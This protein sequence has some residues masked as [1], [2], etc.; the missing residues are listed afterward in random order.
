P[1]SCVIVHRDLFD[2]LVRTGVQTESPLT[3]WLEANY[4]SVLSLEGYEFW[5]R[6][7]RH[8]ALLG[9]A[10]LFEASNVTPR[11]RISVTLAESALRGVPDTELG[12]FFSDMS[13][14]V[15]KWPAADAQ[16]MIT[17]LNSAGAEIGPPRP[18]TFPFEASGLIRLDVLT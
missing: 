18:A 16:L 6:K 15:T 12:R 10:T 13:A 9:T 14:P 4:E 8:V 5:V 2:F 1:R 17:P 3:R 7:N 11:Y